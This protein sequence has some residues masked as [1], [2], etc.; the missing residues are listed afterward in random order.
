MKTRLKKILPLLGVFTLGLTLGLILDTP[1]T[2]AGFFDKLNLKVVDDLKAMGKS[3]KQMDEDI[4][5][6]QD[7]MVNL[8]EKRDKV[9]KRLGVSDYIKDD[10]DKDK[11]D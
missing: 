4:R 9:A 2:E 3:M 7:E 1:T 6:L 10:D 8:R 11:K 5:S